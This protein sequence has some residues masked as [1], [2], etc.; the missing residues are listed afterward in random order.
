[1]IKFDTQKVVLLDETGDDSVNNKFRN[2]TA[3]EKLKLREQSVSHINTGHLNPRVLVTGK[4]LKDTTI[5]ELQ[6][7]PM[8]HFTPSLEKAFWDVILS[9][10]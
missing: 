10:K 7:H 2:E 3:I 6:Y 8:E 4:V 1:M 5:D 9:R